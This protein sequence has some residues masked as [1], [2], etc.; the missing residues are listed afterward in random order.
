MQLSRR[1]LLL[2]SGWGDAATAP[3]ASRLP[4][5]RGWR[6]E[7]GRGD[8]PTF[9]S[10]A[11]DPPARP[12]PPPRLGAGCSPAAC[13]ETQ[14]GAGT[15]AGGGR[16]WRWQRWGP[17]RAAQGGMGWASK[18]KED[19]E[20]V[21]VK[22]EQDTGA[23]DDDDEEATR[24]KGCQNWRLEG[25]RAGEQWGEATSHGNL[26]DL[27]ESES[28]PKPKSKRKPHKCEDC[29]R[30]FN[31]RNHLIRHQRLHTGERPYKCSICGKGFN[32]GS[33]LLIHEMLHRGE[34]PYKCLD[35]GK[36]FSQSSHLISHQVV[37]TNEKPYVCPD[38]GKSFARQQYLLMH[39][40]VHT[41]ERPYECRDCGKSFRKSS[42]LVRHKTVHT[43]EKP[44]K[45]PICGKGFTQNF[46][47]NAHKKAHSKE[48]NQPT[49]PSQDTQQ[50][51]C[52][53]T[54]PPAGDGGY[55]EENPQPGD[56][57]QGEPNR[58][59]LRMEK[60]GGCW[61]LEEGKV[62]KEQSRA[63]SWPEERQEQWCPHEDILEDPKE[64][65]CAKE[66]V[67]EFQKTFD[68]RNSLSQYQQLHAQEQPRKC[69]DC[70]KSFSNCSALTS[71]QQIHQLEK[72]SEQPSTFMISAELFH[73]GPHKSE[74][75]H[76]CSE[77]GKS[78]TRRFN[79][80]LHK[81]LHTGERPHK[82]PECGLS[83][84]NTSHLIVHQRIHTGER[85]YR[86][87]V[88]GKGFTMSSKCLEHERTHTGE[89]PYR[90]SECG[91][92]YRTKVSLM[93]HMKMHMD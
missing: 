46:R 30:I 15:S 5:F 7:R 25:H 52:G 93:S 12:R 17:P 53:T 64:T 47:C 4:S 21:Q 3:P 35:C 8:A 24:D 43:G 65:V 32:D 63:E 41:G 78:F 74:K 34:K 79:L 67:Y 69:P 38:C 44:F 16:G 68:C 20:K 39:R 60:C 51:S 86:C 48:V 81:K 89:A 91:N 27:S 37:H 2:C 10:S 55:Q 6:A 42:D 71:H 54:A 23:A 61:A 28:Q 40:R 92:C 76:L 88:C 66:R 58:S 11:G 45:C 33:P 49:P 62:L 82:C 31:W 84:T 29:G 72:P 59:S 73:Q 56:S 75:S 22:V 19:P 80:K 85:P 13:A 14:E 87:H 26:D 9:P 57:W 77:C 36:S 83:F 70:G 90:C 18:E 50:S 1:L